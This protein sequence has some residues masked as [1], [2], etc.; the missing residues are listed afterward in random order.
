MVPLHGVVRAPL[1]SARHI[2]VKR[3]S[4]HGENSSAAVNSAPMARQ[5]KLRLVVLL[6]EW[7]SRAEAPVRTYPICQKIVACVIG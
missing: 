5:A 3:A 4:S 7:S 1:P 2:A 6:Q